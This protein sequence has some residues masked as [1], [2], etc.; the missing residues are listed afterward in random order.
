MGQ[1]THNEEESIGGHAD[2]SHGVLS[3]AWDGNGLGS[4]VPVVD[5]G[6]C[7]LGGRDPRKQ[8]EGA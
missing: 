4:L 6:A 3:L 7:G 8:C 1:V 5:S 2:P